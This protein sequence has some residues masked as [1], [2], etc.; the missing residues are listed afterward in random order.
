MLLTKCQ[1]TKRIDPANRIV[2]KKGEQMPNFSNIRSREG[3]WEL[4][5]FLRWSDAIAIFEST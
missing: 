3:N 5:E 1:H 4:E 2:K